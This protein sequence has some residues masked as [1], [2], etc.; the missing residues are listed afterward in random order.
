VRA[1]VK[2]VAYETIQNE[3]GSLPL[4]TPMSEVA[5]R[6]ATQIGAFYLQKDHG[7]KDFTRRVTGVNRRQS[8]NLGGGVVGINAARMAVGLGAEVV[9]L[10]TNHKRLEY[11]DDVFQGRLRH[12][13]K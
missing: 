11:L 1:Q 7:G 10:D 8:D 12:F 9:V 5:G 13:F 2:S 4:L 3:D 6:M